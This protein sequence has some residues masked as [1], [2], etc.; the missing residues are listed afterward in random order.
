MNSLKDEKQQADA[1]KLVNFIQEISD[2][3]PKMWGSSIIGFGFYNYKYESGRIGDS[4][5][6]GFSPRASAISLYLSSNFEDRES[7]LEQ[8]GKH[9]TGKGCIYIKSL[10]NINLS[11]LDKMILNHIS[12][13]KEMYTN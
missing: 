3:P 10:T 8:F 6:V 7:L 11:I 5:L 1:Q 4:P 12:H 2:F 13:I 9:K